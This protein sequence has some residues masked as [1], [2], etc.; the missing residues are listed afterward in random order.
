MIGVAVVLTAL[1]MS[2]CARD[3]DDAAPADRRAI[4]AQVSF[5]PAGRVHGRIA[6]SML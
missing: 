2:A 3:I 1:A 4:E 5:R 6:G